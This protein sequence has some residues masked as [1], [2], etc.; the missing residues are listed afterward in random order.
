MSYLS[1]VLFTTVVSLLTFEPII[2]VIPI[3]LPP[4]LSQSPNQKLKGLITSARSQIDQLQKDEG[5]SSQLLSKAWGYLGSIYDVHGWSSEAL[6]CY[7]H[8]IRFERQNFRWLYLLGR[9]TYTTQPDEA[10]ESL[11]RAIKIN[12]QYTPAYVYLVQSLR[13]IGDI[14]AAKKQTK[15][16]QQLIPSNSLAYLWL[17]ELAFSQGQFKQATQ[18]LQM[19]LKFNP[20]QNEARTKLIQAYFAQGDF[21]SANRYQLYTASTTEHQEIE[22]P[23]WESVTD[24]GLS[25]RWFLERANRYMKQQ[26]FR[27]AAKEFSMIISVADN[28]PEIW[29][30]YG[31]C[32]YHTKQHSTATTILESALAL[33]NR[34]IAEGQKT[35]FG[36]LEAQCNYHL[37]LIYEQNNQPDRSIKKYQKAVDLS[38]SNI[39]YRRQLAQVYWEMKMY[40]IAI[41]QYKKIINVE[42]EDEKAIYRIGLIALQKGNLEKA[43][44]CFSRLVSINPNHT[45]AYGALGLTFFQLGA[46]RKAIEAYE[47]ILNIEPD[48]QQAQSMLKKISNID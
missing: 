25:S 12:P 17:G 38:P 46:Q 48:H 1:F 27:S 36:N 35:D 34:L 3:P 39:I 11:S 31:I 28:D 18:Q 19:A 43:K 21:E 9:L 47:A 23:I 37:G 2:E 29:L 20:N 5:S 32:L 15:R 22:D 45:R 14:E 26:S 40:Q 33:Q 10:V 42:P 6:F 8:A 44:S 13:R 24:L 7:Q 4:E 41:E 30:N 16:L